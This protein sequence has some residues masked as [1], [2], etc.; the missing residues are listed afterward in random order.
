VSAQAVEEQYKGHPSGEAGAGL[1]RVVIHRLAEVHAEGRR[2]IW[3]RH[4]FTW[5]C[6]ATLGKLPAIGITRAT[7]GPEFVRVR[8][9]I[10]KEWARLEEAARAAPEKAIGAAQEQNSEERYAGL[11]TTGAGCNS[12]R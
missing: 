2:L 7:V 12:A 9:L 11:S 5:I 3:E 10:A 6:K 1:R 4:C 8:G